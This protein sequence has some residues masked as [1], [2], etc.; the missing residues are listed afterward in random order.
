MIAPV[1][2]LSP[3]TVPKKTTYAEAYIK[4]QLIKEGEVIKQ[5]I[6]MLIAQTAACCKP[7][8]RNVSKKWI[9]WAGGY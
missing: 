9:N 4:A 2:K 3:A 8:C 6:Y 7:G 5:M 1:P